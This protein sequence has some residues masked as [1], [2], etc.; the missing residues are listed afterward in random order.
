VSDEQDEK[1]TKTPQAENQKENL[2]DSK[3]LE[4]QQISL[5]MMESSQVDVQNDSVQKEHL[6]QYFVSP[7]NQP[8]NLKRDSLE[9]PKIDYNRPQI[10]F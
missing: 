3:Y 1:A 10:L 7:L 9:L 2:P 6:D 4:K 5:D 8:N